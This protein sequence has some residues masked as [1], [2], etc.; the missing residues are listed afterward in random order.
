MVENPDAKLALV[1]DDSAVNCKIM[2]TLLREEGYR[3]L[4]GNNG[5]VGVALYIEHLPDLVLMDIH[6]PVM[7]GY[8][9][10]KRIKSL[11][12]NSL[13]PLIFITSLDTD[14]AFVEAIEAGGDGILTRPFSPEVFKA[15]IKSIQ[16]I[17]NLYTQVKTLQQEQQQ[18]A[19][20]AEQIM[21][22][23]IEARNFALDRIGIKKQAA[24]LFSGDIQLTAL[25]P[26]GNVNV[27]L[28]DFTGHGLRSSIG[29]IPLSETF[30]VMTK[31]GFSLM[32]IIEQ[33]N[34]QL[35]ELLPVDLFC[36]VCCVSISGHDRSAYVFNAGLPDTYVFNQEGKIKHK[37]ESHHIPLGVMPNLLPQAQL[38]VYSVAED[39]RVVLISDGILEARNDQGEM[40]GIQ[41]FESAARQGFCHGDI[42]GKVFAAVNDFCQGRPQEDDISLIDIPCN[43][44][45]Q[46]LSGDDN[47]H[48]L[49]V[50]EMPDLHQDSEP[51]WHWQLSL[52]GQRLA[53]VN[54]VP[55]AMGQIQEIE[56]NGEHWNNMYTILTELYVNALD[57]GVLRLN[58][59]LKNSA[60]GF[61]HYFM[62]RE[63]RLKN[64]AT[65]RI[66]I[67]LSY[68]PLSSGGKMIITIVDD[69]QGFDLAA[70]YDH[71]LK[72]KHAGKDKVMLCGRGIE[73][74]HQ[75]C[76]KLEYLERGNK[77]QATYVWA[78]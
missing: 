3:V 52:T 46:A 68:H 13:A 60:A 24:A 65:G 30:R 43:G 69:G 26:G 73:L 12:P 2:T 17:S 32:E 54:P 5:A 14:E 42:P 76:E 63:S 71:R 53:L 34:R 67:S 72:N 70:F 33:I 48:N 37:I 11:S 39:D 6:M 15:K 10:A 61:A 59:E 1:I 16:R 23:V 77:V 55:M 45:Q 8:E 22:G 29:A 4:S 31:K 38:Q 57:H 20:L 40:Y 44:W 18:D 47:A 78:E 51:S 21:S 19:E 49:A 75:L 56:G 27:L 58:S 50:S 28:G 7:D 41:R 35:Y 62:V 64:L 9:A 66:D 36:C 74:V 25:C